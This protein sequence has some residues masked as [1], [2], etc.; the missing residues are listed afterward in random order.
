MCM[1]FILCD[2]RFFAT[3]RMTKLCSLVGV[4]VRDDPSIVK[5]LHKVNGYPQT[6]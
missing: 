3:L 6:A 5:N 2:V 4:G 1:E